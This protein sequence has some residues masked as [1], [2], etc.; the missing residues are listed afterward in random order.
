MAVLGG[1]GVLMSEVPLYELGWPE[2]LHKSTRDAIQALR[3]GGCGGGCRAVGS[4]TSR[5]VSSCGPSCFTNR[6]EMLY[7]SAQV[8]LQI[9]PSCCTNRPELL[10]RVGVEEA[11]GPW[12]L[13]PR[14][15]RR[16]ESHRHELR[17]R[18]EVRN[19]NRRFQGY[20]A[21]EKQRPP[22]ILGCG[23]GCRAPLPPRELRRPNKKLPHP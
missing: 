14:E 4:P 8:A 5:T 11:V 19:L 20:L 23:G 13:P 15:L 7:T 18:G 16:P 2:L 3:E 17:Q 9:G 6:P 21:H 10:G 22:R 1:G 12:G